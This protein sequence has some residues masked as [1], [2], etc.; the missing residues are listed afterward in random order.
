MTED[1]KQAI[2]LSRKITNAAVSLT[3]L[4]V[5]SFICGVA[6]IIMVRAWLWMWRI[7]EF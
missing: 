7:T 3:V 2:A 6:V 4:W 1:S 5:G